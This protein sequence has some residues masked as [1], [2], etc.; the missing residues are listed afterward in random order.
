M[1]LKPDRLKGWIYFALVGVVW[2][3]APNSTVARRVS[4]KTPDANIDRDIVY[5]TVDGQVLK[6]DLFRPK[7]VGHAVPLVVWIHSGG[8]SR[9][10]KERTPATV[11]VNDRY[12]VASIE[13]RLTGKAPF[14]AQ[15]E[16]CKA[17]VRWIRA[18]ASKYNLDPEHIGV[19]GHSSGGH[20]AALL[21]TSGENP[22][23]EG[24]G[25]Y[26]TYS[27]RV[28][29]VCDV[30]GP[31]DLVPMYHE[32][33]EN[34]SDMGPKAH[35]AIEALIGG[36]LAQREKVAVAASP[37]HYV[38]RNDPPFLI[39]HGE[40]DATVPVEQSRTLATALNAAGVTTIL[41]I[42]PHRGHGVGGGKFVPIIK[43]FFDQ[44]LKGGHSGAKTA[45]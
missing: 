38:S 22:E 13:Y 3:S 26:P 34:S 35:A 45:R 11:L 6:L 20:L 10:R 41:H 28:Q 17:A 37:L 29:A 19:W 24:K 16:D 25:A 4:G 15:I 12:A 42:V 43:T 30:S 27:S 40:E 32:V 2:I 14:P 21:G 5:R 39:I 8:W 9:G 7:N 1:E 44:Y 36:P 18:N 23:L 31:S 33:S